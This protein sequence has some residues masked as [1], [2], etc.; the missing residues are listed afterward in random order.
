MFR[1]GRRGYSLYRT[2][3]GFSGHC[4][5]TIGGSVRSVSTGEVMQIVPTKVAVDIRVHQ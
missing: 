5:T 4:R 3:L 2:T 1:D